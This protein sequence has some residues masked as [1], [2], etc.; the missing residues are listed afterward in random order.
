[1]RVCVCRVRVCVRTRCVPG[2]IDLSHI[3]H[4]FKQWYAMRAQDDPSPCLRPI[5]KLGESIVLAVNILK[6]PF[7][8]FLIFERETFNN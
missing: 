7:V 1:M 6:E 5:K 8:A 2:P 4:A 3:T